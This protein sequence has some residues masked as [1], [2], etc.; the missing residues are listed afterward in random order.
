M[1]LGLVVSWCPKRNLRKVMS[2]MLSFNGW[3]HGNRVL[4]L[5]IYA[6]LKTKCLADRPGYNNMTRYNL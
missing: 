3:N 1:T 5:E 6:I 4:A 2:T